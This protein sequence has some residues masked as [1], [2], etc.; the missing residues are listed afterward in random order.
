ML[1][2]MLAA[3]GNKKK[4]AGDAGDGATQAAGPQFSADSAYAYCAAQCA[5]GPRTM[6]SAAHDSCGRWIESKF[7]QYGMDVR[8]QQATLSGY[9]GTPLKAL[10]FFD[11]SSICISA[12]A[13][14][15]LDDCTE[16]LTCPSATLKI[17]PSA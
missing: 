11:A 6:N 4:Q 12:R 3:C 9:D 16:R 13:R 15:S 10:V 5:F 14:M 2:A 1:L 17:S 8:L 7:R